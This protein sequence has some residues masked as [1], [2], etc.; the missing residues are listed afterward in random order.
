MHIITRFDWNAWRREASGVSVALI[1]VFC[2]ASHAVNPTTSLGTE[3]QSDG[4]GTSAR[5]CLDFTIS[6]NN[7]RRS[8]SEETMS[9]AVICTSVS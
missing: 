2:G 9:A 3:R 4:L 1:P 6:P 5:V 8:P 7:S